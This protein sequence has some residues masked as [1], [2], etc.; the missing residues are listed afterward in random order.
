VIQRPKGVIETPESGFRPLREAA[1]KGGAKES[2][3]VPAGTFAATRGSWA[4]GTVWVS[5]EVPALGLVKANL[6]TG[7]LELVKSGGSGAKDL[8]RS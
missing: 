6:K 1:L 8:L 5:D 3:T 7:V 2:V 4:D